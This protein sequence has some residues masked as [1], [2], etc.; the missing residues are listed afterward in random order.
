VHSELLQYE[1]GYDCCRVF[2]RSSE[3]IAK[4]AIEGYGGMSADGEAA[5]VVCRTKL[6]PPQDAGR[7]SDEPRSVVLPR[8]IGSQKH[9]VFKANPEYGVDEA[10]VTPRRSAKGVTRP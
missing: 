1:R 3:K 4:K 5:P 7:V 6:K 9:R 2:W 10:Y 8:L